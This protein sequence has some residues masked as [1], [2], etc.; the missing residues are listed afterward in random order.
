M[1]EA[2]QGVVF[3][4]RAFS[5]ADVTLIAEVVATCS[6]LSRQE[7]ANTVSELLDWRRANGGLKT[8]ECKDLLVELEG[9][10]VL[11]LPP[12][13]SGRPRG[14][15]TRVVC[16]GRAEPRE[17]LRGSVRDVAPISLRAVE[18]APARQLWRE[19]VERYHYLG[20]RV[21]FGAHLRYLV[22]VARPASQVVGCVQLSSP[23]WRMAARD[24]WIG[25]SDAVRARHLQRVV[26]NSRFLILPWVQVDNL[27]SAILA[28]M[29]RRVPDA[30]QRAYGVRPLLVETLVDR[31]RFAGTCYRAANWIELGTTQ[32]RGRNDRARARQGHSPKTIFVY[33]LARRARQRLSAQG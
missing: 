5:R 30:W 32:G 8:W 24:R 11:T 3:K 29:A 23:A 26:N 21:P 27:A 17:P 4:G 14:S 12:L 33:P 20:H 6:G 13:R 18:D 15:R 9:A 16:T 22:E 19:L 2:A 10:G 7:L 1:A 31:E 28:L 25:W